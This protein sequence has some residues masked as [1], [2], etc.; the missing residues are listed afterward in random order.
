MSLFNLARLGADFKAITTGR[1]LQ[2]VHNRIIGR[3]LAPLWRL[4]WR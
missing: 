4:L 1:I 2:R 3:L